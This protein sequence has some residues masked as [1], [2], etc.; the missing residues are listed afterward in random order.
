MTRIYYIIFFIVFPLTVLSQVNLQGKVISEETN[1]PIP[2][3]SIYFNN[4]SVGSTTDTTGEFNFTVTGIFSNNLVVSSIGYEALIY[5]IVSPE[6]LQHRYLFK[7]KKKNVLME[8]I[9]LLGDVA[10]QKYIR[11]FI[12]NFLGTTEE[13]TL[14]DIK[15]LN[16][17]YFTRTEN[18]T[19]GFNA[20]SDT[21][22]VII[23][24]KLGY[25]II[26]RLEDFYYN[27]INGASFFYGYTRYEDL[28]DSKKWKRNRRKAYYGS[29]LHFFRSLISNTL[30][31]EHYRIFEIQ[32]DTV[33]FNK[34]HIQITVDKVIKKDSSSEI[35]L[36]IWKDVLMVSYIKT[37]PYTPYYRKNSSTY[38]NLNH[39]I[40]SYLSINEYPV[41][42]SNYG[43]L[44][45]PLS[46]TFS[47]YWMYEKTANLLPYDYYPSKNDK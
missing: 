28:G 33:T 4:T 24:K 23:N 11:N 30:E 9:L 17:I 32:K 22:L 36:G 25:K 2:G 8:N 10:R 18:D 27:E 13:A 14:S 12:D 34:K 38:L 35:F 41:E 6:D 47:G 31:Q 45:N 1:L 19:S 29:S 7:L 16:A 46:V 21:A 26:F 3:A 20:H 43:S 39:G 40:G 44:I 37:P 15:N 42:I 5:K